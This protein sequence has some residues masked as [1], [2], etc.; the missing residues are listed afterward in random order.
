MADSLKDV[1]PISRDV[2]VRLA[3]YIGILAAYWAAVKSD[4]LTPVQIALFLSAAAWS[5]GFE[6]RFRKPF[7][8]SPIK[9]GLI[10]LG[11]VIFVL[12]ITGYV[13]G[14]STEHFANSI[15]RFLFWNAIVFILSRNKSE[16]DL[17]TLAIIELSLFMISGA[18]I[19]PPL[20][21]PLLFV[22]TASLLYTFHR[23]AILRC[24]P[25][26]EVT[27]GGGGLVVINFFLVLEI[28][29][30]VFLVFPR[31]S[32]RMD[33]A[34]DAAEAR[35][36]LE[37]PVGPDVA[38]RGRETGIPKH[39]E[40]LK[41]RNFD[42]LKT[43]HDQVIHVRITDMTDRKGKLL[44]P[45]ETLY[46]RGA[47]YDRYVNGD[48]HTP[49]R[50]QRHR[51][52]DDGYVNGWTPLAPEVPP[53]RK[54]VRQQ[55]VTTAFAGDLSFCIPDPVR[56]RW[57]QAFYDPSG[58]LFYAT[59]PKGSSQYFVESALMPLDIPDVRRVRDVPQK[60]LDLPP[61]LRRVRALARRVTRDPNA[62]QHVKVSRL[63]QY[64]MRNGFRYSLDPFIPREGMDPVEYFLDKREGFC[65]HYATALTLL[66]RAA[67]VPARVASGFQLHDPAEDGSFWVKNSD[68]HTWVEVW[69]GPE[70]G[71]RTYDA[72]PPEGRRPALPPE[73]DPL[74]TEDKGAGSDE[75]EEEPGRWDSFIVGFNTKAQELAYVQIMSAIGSG[76]L[77]VGEVLV[78]PWGAGTIAVL[79]GLAI[80][81]YLLLP[82]RT[83]HRMRQIVSGFK[84]RARIDFYRNFL[85]ALSRRGI[86]KH[87][88]LTAREFASVARE[89][90]DDAGIDFV[91]HKFYEALYRATPPTA[92]ERRKIDE[93][94]E[95]L[96]K[97]PSKEAA[98]RFQLD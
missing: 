87:P 96:M 61:G 13:G 36:M 98:D 35:A 81:V 52:E 75:E 95:R 69:Y 28:A 19:Q 41:L 62:R 80:V 72:T 46:L 10:V 66:C 92:D 2:R 84:D 44:P 16:Y 47:I 97:S 6:H 8:S 60:Y 78:S 22:S 23:S 5:L 93:I 65:I 25:A 57:K 37:P 67:K 85:W 63:Q 54:I 33:A 59:T 71:W 34:A 11:S 27:K 58:I 90:V 55:I 24:G 20:F 38:T 45:D 21:L 50:K 43:N 70:Y 15:A 73:G 17:W 83:R 68:A 49:F 26:A 48:W 76:L 32:F 91:T 18:F 40:Y 1:S 77:T 7:F 30:L 82:S 14:S 31:V 94:I 89:R 79:V 51:D 39:P 86:R 4:P 56:V 53:G 3:A 29:A 12:F 9:I 42:R 64:L 88:A 74:A